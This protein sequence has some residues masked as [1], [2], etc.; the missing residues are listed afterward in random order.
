M[1]TPRVFSRPVF[2]LTLSLFVA[3]GMAWAGPRQPADP[4]ARM[5]DWRQ[6]FQRFVDRNPGLTSEQLLAIQNL[7]DIDD[8]DSFAT[9]LAP[10]K[11]EA[12]LAGLR[13]VGLVLPHS[14][15]LKLLRSFGDLRLWFVSNG[16]ATR[17]EV[18]VPNCN[19]SYSWHCQSAVCK[20]VACELNG[21]THTG[22][23]GAASEEFDPNN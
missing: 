13:D 7:A 14:D 6:G 4:E 20:D 17:V 1:Q 23:C 8:L 21:T 5:A 19:C 10:E 16:L 12:L 15:Y 22:V 3:T 2:A 9:Y 18:A 11:R